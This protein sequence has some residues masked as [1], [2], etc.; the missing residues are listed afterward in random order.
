MDKPIN[1]LLTDDEEGFAEPIAFWLKSRGYNVTTARSGQEAIEQ[2]KENPPD[3]L[4]LDINMPRM[5]GLQAL[6]R[7]RDFNK[8]LPVVMIT[9]A[10]SDTNNIV[11]AKEL[12]VSGF[13]AKNRS[14]D[15]LTQMIRV[16]LAIHKGLK[17][18][19][20]EAKHR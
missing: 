5:G 2:I 16:T 10:Y 13:F 11:R 7:I 12:G 15:E 3:I 6:E 19:P 4:F 8:D 1:I 17:T 20:D 9:S 18:P 14:F